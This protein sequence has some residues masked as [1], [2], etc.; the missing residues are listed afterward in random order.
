MAAYT[1]REGALQVSGTSDMGGTV[2]AN[3]PTGGPARVHEQ[4]GIGRH[5]IEQA[6][7]RQILDFGDIGGI[8]EELHIKCPNGQW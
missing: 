7:R 8:D 6:R 2:T 5:A 4:E 1:T 3:F